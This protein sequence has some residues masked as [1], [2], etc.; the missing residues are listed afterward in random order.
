MGFP[1]GPSEPEIKVP[2]SPFSSAVSGQFK[3]FISDLEANGYKIKSIGGYRKA[4]TGGGTGPADPDYDKERYSHPYGGSI[5][6]NPSQNPYG[7]SLVTDMP[8]NISEI[9][10]KHGL[11]WGG[12]WNSVKDAMH[13]SAIKREGGNRDFGFFKKFALGGRIHKPIIAMIGEKGPEFVFDANTTAGL[14][15]LAPQLLEKLNFASTKPQLASI[16][17]S[18]ASYDTMS[19][20]TIIV[21]SPSAPSGGRNNNSSG[22]GVAVIP[23]PVDN[24]TE[25]LAMI[26]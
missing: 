26:G 1:I 13:F 19:P 22:G 20:Q 6:I 16:L 7:K 17:Q 10:A 3:G 12:N 18:Y 9:S 4:G 25:I 8:S 14:D 5:D 15:K 24:F 2:C 23:I 21:Q 11:G